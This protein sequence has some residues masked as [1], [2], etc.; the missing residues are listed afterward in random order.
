[1]LGNNIQERRGTRER[2]DVTETST[3]L[4]GSS[5]TGMTLESCPNKGKGS[6]LLYP[7]IEQSL[8]AGC[9]QE[10]KVTFEQSSFFLLMTDP[11]ERFNCE[12]P[13]LVLK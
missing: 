1:M 4:I 7:S 2:A 13:A 8:D 10:R 9:S 3:N 11:G 6:G 5:G 12:S